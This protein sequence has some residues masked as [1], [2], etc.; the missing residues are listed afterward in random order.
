MDVLSS[1]STAGYS[2]LSTDLW[3]PPDDQSSSLFEA[4][5]IEDWSN[6]VV[7]LLA[8]VHN[9][10]CHVREEESPEMLASLDDTWHALNDKLRVHKDRQPLQFKPLVIFGNRDSSDTT[11]P[12]VRY[13][14]EAICLAM[15][16]WDVTQLL[17]LLA[18]PESSRCERL[19]HYQKEAKTFER[20]AK[21][22][23][24]I[25][26]NNR[27]ESNWVGSTQLLSVAGMALTRWAER[28]ALIKCL[29]DMHLQTGWNT[30]KIIDALLSWWGWAGPLQERGQGWD[31]VHQEIG[32]H[33]STAEWMLRMFDCAVISKTARMGQNVIDNNL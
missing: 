1:L 33:A 11:F 14:N 5:G 2:R 19:E 7:L 31:D 3:L 12:T 28:R 15:Q 13:L 30:S 32:P 9:L 24:A 21:R 27:H 20:L 4:W 17:L 29:K 22:V 16:F 23:V 10:L 26:I 8:E 18:T 25:S 6:H